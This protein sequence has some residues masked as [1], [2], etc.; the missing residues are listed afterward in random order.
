MRI[1]GRVFDIQKF[2]IHDGP[3]IRTLVFLKGC[4]LRCPWCS[5]PEGVR[6]GFDVV[7][8][9]D[10][11]VACG[12]CV[13]VC[14]AGVHQLRDVRGARRHRVV[15]RGR[16]TGCG[17]CVA[18]CVHDALRIAGREMTVEEVMAVV[19]QDEPFYQTSGG[20]MTLGGGEP[21]YQPEFALALLTAAR[22]RGI[23]TAIET[24]GHARPEVF[25]RLLAA[26]DSVL[27][28]VKHLDPGI[29][30]TAVGRSNDLI[31]MNAAAALRSG[32]PVAV[33]VPLIPGF[34][35][36]LEHARSLARFV[37]RHANG[38]AEV[39]VELLPYHRLGAAKYA[40]IGRRYKPAGLAAPPPE[41]VAAIAAAM[42]REGVAVRT[43]VA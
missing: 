33:R 29:H 19:A 39:V 5:N 24:C 4:P 20:G 26:V 2:S 35:D 38:D 13:D 11:C 15:S 40:H 10:R 22:R 21:A 17:L 31:L 41:R 42:E 23:H 14:P 6:P 27:I 7:F 34:N 1:S 9:Q 37:R 3:G 25:S 36:D 12:R 8:L 16:C 28:D 43:R 18:A 30:R 32:K